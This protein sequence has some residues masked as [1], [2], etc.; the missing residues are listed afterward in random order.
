VYDGSF[1]GNLYAFPAS[2]GTGNATCAPLWQGL[3]GNWIA[4]SPAVANGVVYL[5]STVGTLYAY[6][7]TTAPFAPPRPSI[8]SLRPRYSLHVRH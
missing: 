1:D 3:T 2:C 5:K 8:K 6:D 4:S 7:L